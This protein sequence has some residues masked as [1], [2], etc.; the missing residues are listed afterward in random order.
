[1]GITLHPYSGFITRGCEPPPETSFEVTTGTTPALVAQVGR[2]GIRVP[3]LLFVLGQCARDAGPVPPARR[4][5]GWAP[6]PEK[7]CR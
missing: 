4:S 6:C 2:M 1:M 7:Q 5:L 3:L